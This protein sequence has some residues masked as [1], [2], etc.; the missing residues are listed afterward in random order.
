MEP[1]CVAAVGCDA[2][3]QTTHLRNL[4]ELEGVRLKYACDVH[5]EF[6]AQT[7]AHFR[8]EITLDDFS[9]ALADHEVEA[10][11]LS[12]APQLH[13]PV[14][15]AAA[16][17]GKAVYCQDLPAETLDEMK[18][19]QTL[20]EDSRI[21]FCVAH[22]RRSA[23]AMVYAAELFR[24]QRREPAPSPWRAEKSAVTRRHWPE[25]D[26]A[27]VTIRV[28]DD[29]MS[30]RPWSAAE[31]MMTHGPML[32]ELPHF[33][34]LANWLVGSRPVTVTAAGHRRTNSAVVVEYADGSLATIM[35]TA[36]GSFTYPREL[37]ELFCN[38]AAI[39]VDDFVE[40]RTGGL[41][42]VAPRRAFPLLRDGVPVA[43]DGGGVRDYCAKLRAAEAMARAAE[44]PSAA[45]R[46]LWPAADKGR[47]AHLAAFLETVRSG[48]APPS[49]CADAILAA[50]VAFAAA[51]SHRTGKPVKLQ[52][53]E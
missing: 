28:N 22:H 4:H 16:E 8:P 34:D 33:T 10:V 50:R 45:S 44:D 47:K 6:L 41:A 17:R 19:I 23:P 32:S 5:A 13:L 20:V 2:L 37:Y 1:L 29:L 43:A 48:G 31:D 38:C 7:A 12:T 3:A 49:S 53:V 42:D 40:V 39:V 21:N 18:E 27:F 36:V 14:I 51:A 52:Y 30:W 35:Q 24:R 25:E 15:R 11:I 9:E 26:Q 46:D